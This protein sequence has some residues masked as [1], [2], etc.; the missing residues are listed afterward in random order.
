[1]DLNWEFIQHVPVAAISGRLTLR[2]ALKV[3]MLVCD[4]ARERGL[5]TFLLDV[6]AVSGELSNF[7]C[8]AL[9]KGV[10]AYCTAR[11]WFY[12]V[13]V[14]GSEPTVTGFGARVASNRGLAVE[15]F[16]DRQKALEW[17]NAFGTAATRN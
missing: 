8:Y 14:L 5:S 17:L 6:S 9:A 1:M 15:R 4:G 2:D 7:E 13:A 10:A 3:C 16:S 12:R 11:G